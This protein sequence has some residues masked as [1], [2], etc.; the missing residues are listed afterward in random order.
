[1][2]IFVPCVLYN[3]F[4]LWALNNLKDNR[5]RNMYAQLGTIQ[6]EQY[7]VTQ[8]IHHADEMPLFWA[9]LCNLQNQER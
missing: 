4:Y 5:F 1:M 9:R 2:G 7:P 3:V 6:E 8:F